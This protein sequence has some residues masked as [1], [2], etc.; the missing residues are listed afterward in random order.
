MQLDDLLAYLA[1]E[2]AVDGELGSSLE[3]IWRFAQAFEPRPALPG[4]SSTTP[5]P[6]EDPA[7]ENQPVVVD[8]ATRQLIWRWLPHLPNLNFIVR[9]SKAAA[10]KLPAPSLMAASTNDQ[11]RLIPMPCLLGAP[12]TTGP[13][14]KKGTGPN[15]ARDQPAFLLYSTD[16]DTLAALAPSERAALWGEFPTVGLA[17]LP[18]LFQTLYR[19]SLTTAESTTPG[20]FELFVVAS[21]SEIFTHLFGGLDSKSPI[22]S[23]LCYPALQLIARERQQGLAV[24][25]ISQ[26]LGTDARSTFHYI[27][28]LVR[29]G[30]VRRQAVIFRKCNTNACYHIGYLPPT[31]DPPAPAPTPAA[32]PVTIPPPNPASNLYDVEAGRIRLTSTLATRPNRIMLFAEAKQVFGIKVGRVPE[33]RRLNRLIQ[34]LVS[35]K[36]I[37]KIRVPCHLVSHE[38][39]IPAESMLPMDSNS[40]MDDPSDDDTASILPAED[41]RTREER[42]G[43]ELA[44]PTPRRRKRTRRARGR[45]SFHMD[46]L[47]DDFEGNSLP[48]KPER[49]GE[50]YDPSSLWV[51]PQKRVVRTAPVDSD[52]DPSFES[53]GEDTDTIESSG[54]EYSEDDEGG[55]Y[56]GAQQ[57]TKVSKSQ[58]RRTVTCIRLL[59]E[60]HPMR[61][62]RIQ[63]LEC[64]QA[65]PVNRSDPGFN[66]ELLDDPE[67]PPLVQWQTMENRGPGSDRESDAPN[68]TC[69]HSLNQ[70]NQLFYPGYALPWAVTNPNPDLPRPDESAEPDGET[71]SRPSFGLSPLLPLETQIYSLLARQILEG[72]SIHDIHRAFPTVAPKFILRAMDLL[73]AASNPRGPSTSS[74]T[75]GERS[76][77]R[78][79]LLFPRAKIKSNFEFVGRLRFR[80]FNIES[81]ETDPTHPLWTRPLLPALPM[82][83][84]ESEDVIVINPNPRKR[85]ADTSDHLRTP[86]P[87]RTHRTTDAQLRSVLL[88]SAQAASPT[89]ADVS[90]PDTITSATTTA[91]ASTDQDE[92]D[93]AFCRLTEAGCPNCKMVGVQLHEVRCAGCRA[94]FHATCLRAAAPSLVLSTWCCSSSCKSRVHQG[95]G[96]DSA[97][98]TPKLTR[99][100]WSTLFLWNGGV[101]A[102]Q[103]LPHVYSKL[104]RAFG[105]P[106][107]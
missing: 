43:L 107:Y 91:A 12:G 48:I 11:R 32:A 97:P 17:Q 2:I 102:L 18:S 87:K 64:H 75:V 10:P 19:W 45:P 74:S 47:H 56:Q 77:G 69:H 88:A 93:F 79:P 23:S 85:N 41:S 33:L 50:G 27:R 36:F 72:A 38:G 4:P 62:A 61:T 90:S 57:K 16:K 13:N 63:M 81:P 15:F 30:L 31:N 8:Q 60:Y 86:A 59:R 82:I 99:R 94:R 37:E 103:L 71:A 40:D 22:V 106:L 49:P 53:P 1:K 35:K 44:S 92:L 14:M 98:S 65:L 42:A 39:E 55:H 6:G 104:G 105:Y 20:D 52:D 26:Q 89:P 101:F 3:R 84:T 51:T 54:A 28:T 70:P 46:R 24:I 96:K 9:P 58:R 100:G 25:N 67:Y 29:E 73:M 83:E 5:A 66:T 78:Y 80:H 95:A 7:L 68:P 76:T 34:W 21:Y